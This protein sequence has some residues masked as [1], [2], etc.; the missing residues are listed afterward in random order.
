MPFVRTTRDYCTYVAWGVARR[1]SNWLRARRSRTSP[2]T[3]KRILSGVSG[4]GVPP[5]APESFFPGIY[6]RSYTRLLPYLHKETPEW[7]SQYWT[8]ADLPKENHQDSESSIL[9]DPQHFLFNSESPDV[10][11]ANSLISLNIIGLSI[12]GNSRKSCGSLFEQG[13]L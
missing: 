2:G 8:L 4:P 6:Q 12:L 5:E 7:H 13:L 10:L 1:L 9:P 3:R 11:S